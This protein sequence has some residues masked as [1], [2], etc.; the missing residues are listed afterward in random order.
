MLSAYSY[1]SLICN[2]LKKPSVKR[3][4]C[5]M[6][7]PAHTNGVFGSPAADLRRRDADFRGNERGDQ[8]IV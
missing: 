7:K 2:C 5:L 4:D 1:E 3:T 8:L 6:K